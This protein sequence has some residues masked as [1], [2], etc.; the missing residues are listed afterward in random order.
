M[1]CQKFEGLASELARGQMMDVELRSDA[2]AH[3]ANCPNCS[4]QLRDQEMLSHGL[5]LLGTQMN[6]LQAPAELEAGLLTAFRQAQVVTQLPMSR[7][8]RRFWF[9]AV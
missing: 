3:G 8:Y 1:N 7:N 6:E 2:E 4:A 9:A 5:R